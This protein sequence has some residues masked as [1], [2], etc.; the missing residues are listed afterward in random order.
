MRPFT[1]ILLGIL[2]VLLSVPLAYAD[3][4]RFF[5]DLG[6]GNSVT[7]THREDCTNPAVTRHIP[8][9]LVG[10]FAAGTVLWEGRTLAACWAPISPEYVFII[11]ETGDNGPMPVKSFVH[12]M[13]VGNAS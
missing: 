10:Q 7:L 9:E 8:A 6:N 12:A 11:D 13:S 2:L 5:L 3:H 4:G 1:Y